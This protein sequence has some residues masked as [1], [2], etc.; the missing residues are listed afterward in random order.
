MAEV[1][2][3]LH[4]PNACESEVR[5]VSA[6]ATAPEM[7]VLSTAPPPQPAP[8]TRSRSRNLGPE[9]SRRARAGK[10]APRV[11]IV[12]DLATISSLLPVTRKRLERTAVPV[13]LSTFLPRALAGFMRV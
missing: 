6:R 10:G 3:I 1:A 13:D 9:R 11:E 7:S 8:N 4:Q 12:D 2:D 5:A